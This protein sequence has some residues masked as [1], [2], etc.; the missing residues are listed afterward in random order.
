MTC[1]QP[2]SGPEPIAVLAQ[3]PPKLLGVLVLGAAF[4]GQPL[5]NAFRADEQAFASKLLPKPYLS[6]FVERR[7]FGVIVAR[8]GE[9]LG[10][11]RKSN[12]RFGHSD[13]PGLQVISTSKS[14]IN[15]K[16]I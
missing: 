4:A 2:P 1:L 9:P 7:A 12:E 6:A 11:F 14:H 3:H 8:G 15:K 13:S 10:K 16:V 5:P